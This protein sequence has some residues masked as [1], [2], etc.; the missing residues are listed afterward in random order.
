MVLSIF[1]WNEAELKND[2]LWKKVWNPQ[3][4]RKIKQITS[5][6]LEVRLKQNFFDFYRLNINNEFIIADIS[7]AEKSSNLKLFQSP[8]TEGCY[9]KVT[10]TNGTS[11]LI[12]N[13]R[14]LIFASKV[15]V[16]PSI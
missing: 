16:I 6:D 4:V 1:E 7:L 14:T 3:R 8:G 12:S 15:K 13:F 11:V 9:L 5:N 10:F 2:T